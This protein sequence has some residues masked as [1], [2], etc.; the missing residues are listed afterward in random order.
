MITLLRAGLKVIRL[1]TVQ[2]LPPLSRAT[3]SG[4]HSS[5]ESERICSGQVSTKRPRR[6]MLL[7]GEGW[8]RTNI[9]KKNVQELK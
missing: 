6:R 9:L 2:A 8:G 4:A 3:T 7:E 1:D 5:G